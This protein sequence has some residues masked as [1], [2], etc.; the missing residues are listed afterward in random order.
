VLLAPP[1]VWKP[2]KESSFLVSDFS[3]WANLE[4]SQAK[5]GR[6]KKDFPKKNRTSELKSWRS[7]INSTESK[8]RIPGYIPG[9]SGHPWR[10]Q[11][12]GEMY[13]AE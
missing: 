13:A 1:R 8:R 6:Q 5:R 11:R 3:S 4:F 9:L 12:K 2:L 10:F 7:V